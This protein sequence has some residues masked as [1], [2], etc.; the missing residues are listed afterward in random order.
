MPKQYLNH[1]ELFPSQQYGFSQIVTS[2][3]GKTVYLSG[4]VAWDSERNIVGPDDLRAQTIQS[5]RNIE[6]ALKSAG[7]TITDVVSMRIYIVESKLAEDHHITEALKTFFPEERLPASTWVGVPAL[8]DKDFLV[9][10]EAVAVI[11]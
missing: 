7:G 3:G 10:I 6:T 8:S 11:E 9:E 2:Q 1:P 5:L 4:Q